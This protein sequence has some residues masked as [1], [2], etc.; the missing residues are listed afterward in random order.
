VRAGAVDA[1]SS[2]GDVSLSLR[3]PPDRL[4]ATSSGGDVELV[5]PDEAYRI[6]ATSSGGD[7]DDQDVRNAPSSPRIIRARSSG[8][9]VRIEA[10]R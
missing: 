3:T 1:E 5:L 7:V 4:D 9:D 10:R 8:G 6:D 2:G